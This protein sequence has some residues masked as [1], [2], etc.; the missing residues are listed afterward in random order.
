MSFDLIVGQENDVQMSVITKFNIY[1]TQQFLKFWIDCYP[2]SPANQWEEAVI[3]IKGTFLEI[4][5]SRSY[6]D[7]YDNVLIVE[8]EAVSGI[9][10]TQYFLD[11]TDEILKVQRELY[12]VE[13]PENCGVYGHLVFENTI[14]DVIGQIET[15]RYTALSLHVNSDSPYPWLLFSIIKL[16][17]TAD[18]IKAKIGTEDMAEI[19]PD[20]R[21][22][23]ITVLPSS[24]TNSQIYAVW[25]VPPPMS[26][27]EMLT[28]FP[29]SLG[30]AFLIGILTMVVY[31]RSTHRKRKDM[32]K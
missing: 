32:T 8:P 3:K 23:T 22:S 2:M 30:W 11:F 29:L 10:R 26:W 31:N 1:G 15:K 28:Q 13:S 25:E 9:N 24:Q 19:F 27:Q 16:P 6:S 14:Y 21:E 7:T 20:R 18:W 12:P 4:N 17:S 5:G